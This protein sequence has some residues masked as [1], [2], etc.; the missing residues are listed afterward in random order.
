MSYLP[1]WI[2]L[3]VGLVLLVAVLVRV[4]RTVRRFGTTAASVNARIG[5]ETGHLRARSAALRVAMKETRVRVKHTPVD[6]PSGHR[7]RQEDDRG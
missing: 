4:A 5:D 3:A 2:V 1:T 7:G 6:V